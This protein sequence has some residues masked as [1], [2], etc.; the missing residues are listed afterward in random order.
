MTK[1]FSRVVRMASSDLTKRAMRAV[2]QFWQSARRMAALPSDLPS[3]APPIFQSTGY[4]GT[5]SSLLQRGKPPTTS[6]SRHFTK[7]TTNALNFHRQQASSGTSA[8][9]GCQAPEMRIPRRLHLW[10]RGCVAACSFPCLH[11]VTLRF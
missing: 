8:G 3:C 9:P 4:A 11:S 2:W 5:A 1:A 6:A 7:L 10:L